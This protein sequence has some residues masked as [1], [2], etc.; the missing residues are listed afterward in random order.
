MADMLHLMESWGP[1][2][3]V[4]TGPGVEERGASPVT[5]RTGI[6]AYDYLPPEEQR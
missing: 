3:H 1:D 4:W 2:D 5:G 6:D